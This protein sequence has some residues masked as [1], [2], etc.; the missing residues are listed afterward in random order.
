MPPWPLAAIAMLPPIR[1]A[2][3][4]N[5]FCSATAGSSL[6]SSRMRP[7]SL[8]VVRHG[9]IVQRVVTLGFG[10]MPVVAAGHS[11]RAVVLVEASA[12]GSRSRHWPRAGAWICRP[13]GVRRADRR[14]AGDRECAARWPGGADLRLAGL[15]DAGEE[16]WFR[17][18]LGGPGWART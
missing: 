4:P 18:A 3:P 12:I 7:A 16:R 5:I 15:C 8:L 11:A 17:R 1:N 10:G 2:R 13:A 9:A 6:T 14:R